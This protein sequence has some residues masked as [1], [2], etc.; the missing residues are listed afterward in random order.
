MDLYRKR[1]AAN[2]IQLAQDDP[3]L[4]LE[5]IEQ[6]R[7]SGEIEADDLSYLE[8][9]AYRWIAIAHENLEKGKRL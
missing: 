8:R 2:V 4:V 5:F 9:I 7:E 6:L 3:D 1:I